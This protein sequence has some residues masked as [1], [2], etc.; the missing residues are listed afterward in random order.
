MG[1]GQ[2]AFLDLHRSEKVIVYCLT[3]ACVEFFALILRRLPALKGLKV[4]A[5]HGKLKQVL[6]IDDSLTKP[7]QHKTISIKLGA[8]LGSV[9]EGAALR[10]SQAMN[11]TLS[12]SCC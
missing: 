2:V 5:L 7:L 8:F 10:G 1:Y 12:C 3:C 9:S 6:W 11:T 4:A